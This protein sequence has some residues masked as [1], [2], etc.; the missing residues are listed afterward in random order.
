[1][2]LGRGTDPRGLVFTRAD[3][4]PLDLDSRTKAFG[5][6]VAVAD[7]TWLAVYAAYIPSMQA[8]AALRV[9]AWLR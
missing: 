5:R 1:M 7:V 4:Q 3:G 9:D 6:L 2:K 8:D